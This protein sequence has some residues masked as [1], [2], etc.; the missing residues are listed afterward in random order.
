MLWEQVLQVWCKV[1]WLLRHGLVV[2]AKRCSEETLK[3]L[4]EI[5]PKRAGYDLRK[6]LLN[7]SNNEI[8]QYTCSRKNFV[9]LLGA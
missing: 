6:F 4:S 1:G 2:S 8:S 7:M 3:R 5:A 9:F